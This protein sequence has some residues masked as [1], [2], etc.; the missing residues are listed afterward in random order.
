[1]R[2]TLKLQ[3]STVLV[4]STDRTDSSEE[5]LDA[6]EIEARVQSGITERLML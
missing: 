6:D 2:L 3:S 5:R 1:M 4:E